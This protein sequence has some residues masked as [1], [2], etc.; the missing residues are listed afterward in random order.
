MRRHLAT[1]ATPRRWRRRRTARIALAA[2]LVV[3]APFAGR[4]DTDGTG[5]QGPDTTTAT[6][7]ANGAGNAGGAVENARDPDG[8]P[9]GDVRVVPVP[10]ADPAVAG[11]LRPGDLVDLVS[12]A[13]ISPDPAVDVLVAR[14]ALVREIHG[15]RQGSGSILVEV[16]RPEA[17]RI[18]A[19]AAGTP[20]AVIVH[21]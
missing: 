13:D 4:S 16:P 17:A 21:G 7:S 9:A 2:A 6:A 19:I 12:A 14:A 1:A 8:P 18:A 5:T 20:L 3:L 11:L 15:G 10:L